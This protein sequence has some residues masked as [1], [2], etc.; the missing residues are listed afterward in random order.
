MPQEWQ[1]FYASILPIIPA[2]IA[3]ALTVIGTFSIALCAVLARFWP[4]PDTGSKWMYL[5]LLV[6][7]VAMNSRHATNADDTRP[8]G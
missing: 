6:N 7:R 2:E 1:S 8:G 3:S 4:R 5:Y